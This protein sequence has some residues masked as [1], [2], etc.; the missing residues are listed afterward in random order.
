MTAAGAPAAQFSA[1]QVP[2]GAQ[3]GVPVATTKQA[4]LALPENASMKHELLTS[5]II[6]YVCAAIS[7]VVLVIASNNY[8]GLIDIAALVGLGLGI[9]LKQS[10]VCAIILLVYAVINAVFVTVQNGTLGGWLPLIAGICAVI[11]TFKL[12]K[13][14]K[15]YQQRSLQDNYIVF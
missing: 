2:M 1:G 14:W 3:R 13:A 8:F 10:K 11:Y 12:D 5:A 9:H 15:A 7:L 6:C 4:F